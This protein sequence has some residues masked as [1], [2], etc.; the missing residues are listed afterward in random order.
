MVEVMQPGRKLTETPQR[1]APPAL[2]V[3]IEIDP[4][5]EVVRRQVLG[6]HG[7]N[8]AHQQFRFSPDHLEFCRRGLRR[9]GYWQ[10]L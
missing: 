4:M 10:D 7:L 8:H 2:P 1:I 3:N 5:V 6:R 9:N